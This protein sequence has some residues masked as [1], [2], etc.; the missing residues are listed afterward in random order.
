M[1]KDTP[2]DTV[3]L[4]TGLGNIGEKYKNTRH[5]IGFLT[6]DYLANKLNSPF[7]F[8]KTLNGS[9]SQINQYSSKKLILL[10]PHTFMNRSGESVKKTL[11]Y[12]KIK[13]DNLIIIHDDLDLSYNTIR[14]RLKGRS[15]GHNGLKSIS[16][17]LGTDDFKRIKAGISNEHLKKLRD[18]SS[19]DAVIDFVL[20]KFNKEEEKNLENYCR[21]IAKV[22]EIFL[23]DNKAN[24]F[25]LNNSLKKRGAN[26]KNINQ[27]IIRQ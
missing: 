20:S 9:I 13:T 23:N 11:K 16:E 15:G 24:T 25:N 21:E 18:F 6:L 1:C 14:T 17:H 4:V 12:F 5:N 19:K 2:E 7:S 10:K 27:K 8:K 3:Y 22:L 26:E